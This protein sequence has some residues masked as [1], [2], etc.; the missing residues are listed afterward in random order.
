M[1]RHGPGDGRLDRH[2]QFL[3]RAAPRR[4]RS[5]RPPR[6]RRGAGVERQAR[7]DHGRERRR[8]PR[9]GPQRPVRAARRARPR[10]HVGEP[11]A[12]ERPEPLALY[13]QGVRQGRHAREGRRQ[14]RLYA[15][16]QAPR[17]A[18][19]RRGASAPLRGQGEVLRCGRCHEGARRRRGRRRPAGRRRAGPQLLAGQERPR[20][21]DDRVGRHRRR[22]ARHRHAPRRIRQARRE[23][24]RRRQERGRRPRRLGQG[25]ARSS[26]R[27]TFSPISPTRRWS[28]TTASSAAPTAAPN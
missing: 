6:R 12:A 4:S 21:A 14:R 24:R 22:D 19:L 11:A 26:R 27:P 8:P 18:D 10:H 28:R 2:G 16:R 1:G 17:H 7:R 9:L 23:A 25:G 5:A 13:R 15:R 20:R 3:G